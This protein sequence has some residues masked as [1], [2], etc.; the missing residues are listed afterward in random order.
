MI[1]IIMYIY[2]ALINA[3]SARMI[4]IILNMIF[5]THI[6]HSSTQTTHTNNPPPSAP[7]RAQH[8]KRIKL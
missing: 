1:I 7:L 6:E 3:L 2:H 8:R 5:F 4:H